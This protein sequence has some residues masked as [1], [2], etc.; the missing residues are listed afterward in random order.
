M[1]FF[2]L[3]LGYSCNCDCIHCFISKRKGKDL[4]FSEIKNIVDKL[5]PGT[6]ITVTGGEPTIRADI[7]EILQYLYKSGFRVFLQTNGLKLADKD[8]TRKIVPYLHAVLYTFHSYIPEVHNKIYNSHY[9]TFNDSV[10][11]LINISQYDIELETQTVISKYNIGHLLDTCNYIQKIAP[12]AI[13]KIT[14]P[15]TVGAAANKE[16]VPTYSEIKE[17]IQQVLKKW[18]Y[19]IFTTY[20]PLCYIYPYHDLRAGINNHDEYGDTI[21]IDAG[22][23][24]TV[25]DDVF[26]NEG[27][28]HSYVDMIKKNKTKSIECNS[29]VFYNRCLGIWKDYERLFGRLDVNPIKEIDSSL[30]DSLDVAKKVRIHSLQKIIIP[31]GFVTAELILDNDNIKDIVSIYESLLVYDNIVKFHIVHTNNQLSLAQLMNEFSKYE[32]LETLAGKIRHIMP[33]FYNIPH[34]VFGSFNTFVKNDNLEDI[35]Y[36]FEECQECIVKDFCN[37]IFYT[38][39]N[40]N[41][42]AI[43]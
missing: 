28:I 24:N 36:H 43:K 6:S 20:I 5:H 10:Q 25:K 19:K 4:S 37:G 15:H 23:D 39:E 40:N 18:H 29:C 8:F 9:D 12:R 3:K 31:D 1:D 16:L 2:D 38:E 13:M 26:F 41:L 27:I 21:N 17:P 11:G 33:V 32:V 35:K 30:I 42:K 7:I 14:Y 34:C 22:I